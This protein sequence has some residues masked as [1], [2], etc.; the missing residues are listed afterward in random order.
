MLPTGS[1]H[2]DWSRACSELEQITCPASTYEELYSFTNVNPAFRQELLESDEYCH[3]VLSNSAGEWVAFCEYSISRAEW[4]RGA[5]R[6]GWIDYIG[7]R[8]DHQGQGLGTVLLTAALLRLQ[9][10]GA[11]TAILVTVSDNFA[12][13][14]LYMKTGFEQ[15]ESA[16]PNR[17]WC[18]LPT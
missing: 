14:G 11:E 9:E 15:I 3:L 10:M 1:E 13:I 2:R 12:A 8:E 17:F 7:T 18:E 4:N 16:I 6:L 5:E